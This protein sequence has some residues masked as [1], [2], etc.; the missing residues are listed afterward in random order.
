MGVRSQDDI[1]RR[2]ARRGTVSS[3]LAAIVVVGASAALVVAPLDGVSARRPDV[4]RG[5]TQVDI[6]S[7]SSMVVCPEPVRL[8]QEQSVM[9]DDTLA[10]QQVSSSRQV[11]LGVLGRGGGVAVSGLVPRG[12]VD[13]DSGSAQVAGAPSLTAHDVNAPAVRD[14]PGIADALVAVTS[15]RG[16]AQSAE[17]Q[18]TAASVL[19][20]VDGGDRRGTVGAP[21]QVASSEQWLVGGS[22]QLG[23]S[24]ALRV[25]NPSVTAATVTVTMW[26]PSGRVGLPGAESLLVPPGEQVEV[27]LEG[28]AAQQRRVAVHVAAAGALVTAVI[29]HSEL[30]GITPLGGDLVVPGASPQQV[31]VVPGVVVRDRVDDAERASVVRVVAP[32]FSPVASLAQASEEDAAQVA[33]DVVGQVRVTLLG[34]DGHVVL[35]GATA[36]DLV[37]GQVIDVPLTG[38]PAGEY[39]V[40]VDA[41]VPVLAGARVNAQAPD[42]VGGRFGTPSDFAWVPAAVGT[43]SAENSVGVP[44]VSATSAVVLPL[45]VDA[46]LVATRLPGGST[47]AEV[48]SELDAVP[49]VYASDESGEGDEQGG[50]WTEEEQTAREAWVVA[51]EAV[52]D[53]L[54]FDEQG[55]QLT[56]RTLTLSVGQTN[57]L[58]MGEFSGASAVVVVPRD[59]HDGVVSWSVVTADPEIPGSLSVFAPHVS[60]ADAPFVTVE[61]S[62]R[63]GLPTE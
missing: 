60:A 3:V 32:D 36:H 40:V 24:S 47:Q 44:F 27:L 30:D 51:S 35:L 63:A 19:T 26:G 11:R 29:E 17:G 52:A 8:T 14:F 56:Q 23:A 21:C 16:V 53:V 48:V 42:D 39:S 2:R 10:E 4:A 13:D 55:G 57:S 18:W 6:G 12:G 34:P 20:A 46:T 15:D 61:R 50:S 37:A 33:G 1:D 9:V 22:T 58:N 7:P 62:V 45:G 31:Q 54:V 59:G 41:D 43:V 25:M 38:V 28:V 49:N 5:L